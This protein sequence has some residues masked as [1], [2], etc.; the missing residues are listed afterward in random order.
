MTGVPFKAVIAALVVAAGM[1]AQNAGD[2]LRRSDI[3]AFAPSSF[4]ARLTLRAAPSGVAHEVEVWRSGDAKTLIRF[5]DPKERG[6]YLHPVE[7]GMPESR[8]IDYETFQRMKKISARM[9]D[10]AAHR[11]AGRSASNTAATRTAA[12]TSKP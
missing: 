9:S 7:N 8:G 6:K 1:A 2:L 11:P 4:R 5:L 12:L 10:H 3:G